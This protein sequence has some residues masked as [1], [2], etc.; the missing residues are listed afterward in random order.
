ME[1]EG[2]GQVKEY[3]LSNTVKFLVN[4]PHKVKLSY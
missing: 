1:L 2:F 4:T 3:N